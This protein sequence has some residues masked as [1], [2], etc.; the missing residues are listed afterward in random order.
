MCVCVRICVVYGIYMER[1]TFHAQ[2][3]TFPFKSCCNS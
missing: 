3:T 2:V 1:E